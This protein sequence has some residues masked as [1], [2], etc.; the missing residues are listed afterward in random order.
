MGSSTSALREQNRSLEERTQDLHATLR[1]ERDAALDAQV[2]R[3]TKDHQ[4]MLDRNVKA[5]TETVKAQYAEHER[6]LLRQ[7]RSMVE[8]RP[9]VGTSGAVGLVGSTGAVGPRGPRARPV[10]PPEKKTRPK[11][12]GLRRFL[13]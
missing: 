1:K 2:A 13:M 12:R 3:L 9:N 4:A 8:P 6:E 11:K 7:H 5:L 10:M